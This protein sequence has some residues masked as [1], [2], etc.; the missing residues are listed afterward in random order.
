MPDYSDDSDEELGAYIYSISHTAR[1]LREEEAAAVR[2]NELSP[3]DDNT[4]I[5]VRRSKRKR[6]HDEVENT[7]VSSEPKERSTKKK[8]KIYTC[9]NEGCANQV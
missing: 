9:G 4:N 3:N 1:L 2:K 6:P 8:K 5:R 7:S